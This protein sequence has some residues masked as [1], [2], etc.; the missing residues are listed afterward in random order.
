M[1]NGSF[2]WCFKVEFNDGTKWAVAG[3]V[4]YAKESVRREVDIMRFLTEKT[5]F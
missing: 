3:K 4:I 5:Y 1:K 2:N